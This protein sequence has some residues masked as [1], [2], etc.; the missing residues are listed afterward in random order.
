MSQD[1]S[2]SI[3]ADYR[4]PFTSFQVRLAFFYRTPVTGGQSSPFSSPYSNPPIS[5]GCS[6]AVVQDPRFKSQ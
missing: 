5:D 4:P 6:S 3:L 2:A 1:G